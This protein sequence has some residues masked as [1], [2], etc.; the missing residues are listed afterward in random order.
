MLLS[1]PFLSGKTFETEWQCGLR[2][3]K[4]LLD[5]QNVSPKE[6]QELFEIMNR[7][8]TWLDNGSDRITQELAKELELHV[9]SAAQRIPVNGDDQSLLK[10]YIDEWRNYMFMVKHLPLPFHFL[11]RNNPSIYPNNRL[12]Q[13]DH[14]NAGVRTTMLITW[15]RVI[16]ANVKARL[17]KAAM[18]IVEHE[19]LGEVVSKD[20]V[21]GV[22]ESFVTLDLNENP[23]E[24][25]TRDFEKAYL[26]GTARFYKVRAAEVLQNNG[27]LNYVAYA[28]RKLQEEQV[29]A[30]Q[31]LDRSLPNSV[32]SLIRQCVSI[33]VSDYEEQMLAECTALI[34]K[35]DIERLQM[36]YR[37]V[38]KTTNGIKIMLDKLLNYIKQEGLEQMRENAEIVTTD[39]DKYVEQLL[40][41]HTRFTELIK[42]A[43]YD[44]PS[45]LTVR[46]KAFQEIVNS[47]EVFKLEVSSKQFK[48]AVESRSPELLA[49]YC[50]QLLRKTALSKRLSSEEI[51]EKLNHVLLV[52]KYVQNKDVFMRFHKTHM[53]RRLVLEIS[54]DQE[55]EEM[56]VRRF[57]EIGMPA[58]YVNKLSRMLQDIE[59][60]KDTN[61]S[62]KSLIA[63]HNNNEMLKFADM[64]HLKILNI[65]AWGKSR[66]T[67]VTL[68]REIEDCSAEVEEV[69]KKMHCGRK[70]F[71]SAQ[72]STATI[73]YNTKHGKYDF[74]VS[75]LQLSILNVFNER[76]NDKIS[77]GDLKLATEIGDFEMG[78]TMM[79]LVAFPK[80]KEQILLT[81]VG[82]INP[83]NFNDCSLFWVNHE[84][85][86]FKNDKPQPRGKL[87][88]IGRLNVAVDPQVEL[89]CEE[90]MQ[91]RTFRLQEAIV[92][93]MKTRRKM[94][95]AQLQTE[96]V[97]LLKQMFLPSRKL[98]KEQLEWLIENKYLLPAMNQI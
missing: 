3:I 75:A 5:Q 27:I 92:K 33:L 62:V 28:D 54:S 90:V 25:Y 16:F 8:T 78:R 71:W 68:P 39:C 70:L 51:D 1:N 56:L 14:Y 10:C 97:E 35:N 57:R 95:S 49:N 44:D 60:N 93:I 9:I 46:D 32:N 77:F 65:G 81:D 83:K 18:E 63:Q 64:M 89:E 96:L 91:L 17:V 72:M 98:I 50:D 88:L 84:F 6:W 94:T 26:E 52:L 80:L 73:V 20:C 2:I 53:S 45:F 37:L 47:T 59:V 61:T 76:Q 69:Y 36:I 40:D 30:E 58:D 43:F 85:A 41:L 12:V 31:Y 67:P 55:K 86:L 66:T 23:L 82:N 21:I 7:L 48:G 29:R 87:N 74:D 24:L 34:Q 22:R 79:S 4:A 13:Q 19:R 11:T 15:H 42:S 38:S